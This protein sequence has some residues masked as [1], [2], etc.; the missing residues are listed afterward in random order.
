MARTTPVLAKPSA[1]MAS[2]DADHCPRPHAKQSA[3]M[4]CQAKNEARASALFCDTKSVLLWRARDTM[5]ARARAR[6]WQRASVPAREAAS[7]E[8][9]RARPACTCGCLWLI[10]AHSSVQA[11]DMHG[12]GSNARDVMLRIGAIGRNRRYNAS[13][14]G[15][16][17]SGKSQNLSKSRSKSLRSS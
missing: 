10:C 5:L 8:E 17:C 4:H 1:T 2:E 15:R 9:R 16:C 14:P 13:P 6:R 12:I 3:S 7:S 11:F